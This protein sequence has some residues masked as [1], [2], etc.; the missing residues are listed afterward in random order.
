[1]PI[2]QQVEQTL[3][4]VVVDVV[5][6]EV[7]SGP[8][9]ACVA[10]EFIEV[11]VFAGLHQGLGAHVGT[12]D[13]QHNHTIGFFGKPIRRC[14]DATDLAGVWGVRVGLEQ[15]PRQVDESVIQ[16]L[17]GVGNLIRWSSVKRVVLLDDL[18]PSGRQLRRELADLLGGNSDRGDHRV[19]CVKIQ[20]DIGRFHGVLSGLGKE[21]S[22]RRLQ[23]RQ[24]LTTTNP[25]EQG[26]WFGLGPRLPRRYCDKPRQRRK[27]PAQNADGMTVPSST[28]RGRL[29]EDSRFD[30]RVA[31]S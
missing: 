4:G 9:S 31:S 27:L 14:L 23:G 3:R 11:R 12:P 17:L 10:G 2:P 6:L 18:A 5:S 8:T 30:P 26:R 7:Q 24:R 25:A 13:S 1:M 22:D 19:R 15:P 21:R 16:W 29:Y 20:V 28:H